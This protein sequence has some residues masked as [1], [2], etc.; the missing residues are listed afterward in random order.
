MNENARIVMFEKDA[1]VSFANCGLPTTWAARSKTGPS[2]WSPPRNFSPTLRI[3]VRTRQEVM[4]IDRA[5]KIVTVPDH[6]T[7]RSYVER[8]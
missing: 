8:L 1:Y 6:T 3:D 5:A 4:A 2:C 7:G